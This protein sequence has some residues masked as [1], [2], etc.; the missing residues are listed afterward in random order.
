MDPAT[1]IS[2]RFSE[3]LAQYADLRPVRRQPMRLEELVGLVLT[4]TGKHPERVHA[5]LRSGT[6]VYNIYR[7]WWDG[8]ELDPPTLEAVLARFPD[9]D[10]ARPFQPA[11]C[12][13][14]KFSDAHEPKPHTVFIERE[15]AARRRWFR[16]QS[17]WD[18]LMELADGKQPGYVDY[19]YYDRADLY[20]AELAPSE[21]A[22][23]AQ[24]SRRLAPRRLW[25][26]LARGFAW[27][28]LELACRR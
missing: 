21:R 27:A 26:P 22:R 12:L 13:W 9:P 4:S 25:Q 7:Y 3:D 10:P 17:F 5:L 1:V 14:V 2:V 11:D 16:R 19:S 28:V 6:C 23:L 20:R 8:F 24:E 18:F 15:Q